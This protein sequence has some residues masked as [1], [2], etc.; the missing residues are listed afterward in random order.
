[1]IDVISKFTESYYC[2]ARSLFY[3][4]R[5]GQYRLKEGS[6]LIF[7][8]NFIIDL[9]SVMILAF[10][11]VQ[12][13][14]DTEKRF[15]QQQLFLVLSLVTILML[16]ADMLSRFDGHPD[17][18][19][20]ALNHIGNF[21]VFL[22]NLLISSL[23]L[24]YTHYRIFHDENKIKHLLYILLVFNGINIA[25][26][27]LSQWWGLLYSID[28]NNIYHR[29]PLFWYPVSITAVFA[30][31]SFI[32][33]VA[34]RKRIEQ[35]HFLSVLLFPIPPLVCMVLQIAFYGLSLML[36]GVAFSLL[37]LFVNMQN[38]S[39]NTDYLTGAYNRK[40]LETYMKE[41]ISASTKNKSFSA[42]LIDLDDFK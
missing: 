7:A 5:N 38:R 18:I 27:I 1:M 39:M 13:L 41:K 31:A 14:K 22:L 23:W 37:I 42:I 36:N 26:L 3:S 25:L 12:T 8:C 16:I 29:G 20:P 34:N 40:K 33:I 6:I 32:L 21:S 9:Y 30:V 35:I 11:C 28:S 24:L 4:I 10:I 15:L 19:Y 17:S 2:S